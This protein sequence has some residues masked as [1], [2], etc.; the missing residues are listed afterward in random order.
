MSGDLERRVQVLED[1]EAIRRLKTS[2]YRSVDTQ[3]VELFVS[4]FTNDAVWE[5]GIFGGAEGIEG[6]RAL[7]LAIP[8][9]LKFSMHYVTNASIE[10]NGDRAT[11]DWYGLVACTMAA[12]GEAAWGAAVV[13]EEYARVDGVWK[14]RRFTQEPQFWTPFDSGWVEERFVQKVYGWAEQP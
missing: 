14:I 3:D 4:L 12:T 13:H 5:S 1:I 2:H 6:I 9:R 8:Q 7:A 11:G 10:V